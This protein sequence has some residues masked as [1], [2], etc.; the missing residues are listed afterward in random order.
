MK[1]FLALAMALCIV[2]GMVACSSNT[3]NGSEETAANN[4]TSATIET[5]IAHDAEMTVENTETSF[6]QDE[7]QELAD[8][9]ICFCM[10]ATRGGTPF[11]D[12]VIAKLQEIA[13]NDPGLTVD[14][15]EAQSTADWEPNLIAAANGGYDL[16]LGFCAQM[17]DTMIKVAEQYP[18]QKFVSIDN[19]IVGMDNV[20]SVGGNCNE[21]CYIAG[22]F[23][24]MLTTRT[25][26]P[27]INPE[28][29]VA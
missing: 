5:D 8:A 26:I 10:A 2:L 6:A 7:T 18:D 16:I 1:R 13:A 22:V 15:L 11:H 20:V 23:C 27:H 12:E 3:N 24:A 29:K 28:K 21:G 4:S 19:S 17:K 25:E 9:K 14:F